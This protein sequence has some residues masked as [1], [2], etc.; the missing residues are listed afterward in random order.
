M[1]VGFWWMYEALTKR[2]IPATT[3]ISTG[4]TSGGVRLAHHRE[5]IYE[6]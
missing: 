6:L 2:K 3:A 5:E 1:R 4:S